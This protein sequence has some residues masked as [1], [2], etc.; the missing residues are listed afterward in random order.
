MSPEGGPRSAVGF[1]LYAVTDRSLAGEARLADLLALLCANGLKGV[2]IREKDLPEKELVRLIG[3]CRPAFERHGTAWF[4]NSSAGTA[5][6]TGASGVHLSSLQDV[7]AARTLMGGGMLIGKSVHGAG[8]AEDARVAGAD[9]LVFGPVYDTPSKRASGP[10]QGLERLREVCESVDIPVFA[11]GGVS[12]A[13]AAECRE[14]GAFGA[15]A[16][17]SLMAA[18]E[19]L[20]VMKE[21]ERS[22][23]TL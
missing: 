7:A 17:S 9:F 20:E 4:V 6:R 13:R 21:Y 12:P 22:L 18:V 16:M 19:P 1:R 3:E 10:P 15:A 23:G 5:A 11:I 2:Q 8:E 14:A